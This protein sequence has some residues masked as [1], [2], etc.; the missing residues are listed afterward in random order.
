ML[1]ITIDSNRHDDP[2]I[3][4]IMNMLQFKMIPFK[5]HVITLPQHDKKTLYHTVIAKKEG[6]GSN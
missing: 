6:D 5:K 4:G 1:K 3:E 2:V